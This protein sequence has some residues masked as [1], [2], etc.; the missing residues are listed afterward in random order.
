MKKKIVTNCED[1]LYYV[2]DEEYDC[3]SCTMNLDEDDNVR[4]T[5]RKN[6]SCPYYRNGDEYLTVRKQ[7]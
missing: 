3:Y 4:L 1:C 7:N 6:S 5:Y 2:Y